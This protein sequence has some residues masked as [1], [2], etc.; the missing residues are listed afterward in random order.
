[1][2]ALVGGWSFER[3]KFNRA[4]QASRQL[5]SAFKPFVWG[6][7]LEVGFT[8][9]DTLFDGP[10]AFPG[11]GG[12]PPYS[13]RN[14]SREYFGITTLRRALERSINVTAV[15][16]LDLVGVDRVIEFANRLGVTSPLPPVLSLALGSA[17]V[18]PME[19]AAAY[20]AI[21]NQ[22]VWV[23]PYFI[24]SVADSRGALLERARPRALRSLSPQVAYVLTH[25][26]EGVVDRGTAASISGLD[27]D[28]AGKTGTTDQYSDA[29]FVGFT[30]RYTLLVW[31]GHDVKRS[32]GRQM[33][34]TRVALPIWA[35]LIEDG[36][37]NGW[38]TEGERFTPPPGVV[39]QPVEL[40]SGLL[41]GP[42]AAAIVEEAFLAG[43]QPVQ[44]Y[45]P[46]WGQV[47][48]RPWYLQ[49]PHYLPKAGE[50]MPEDVEDWQAVMEAWEEK[51]PPADG[52]RDG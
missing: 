50:R 22:G 17:D 14:H 20:A 9:A 19:V 27:I 40:T 3:S 37:E 16:L 39:L 34:G 36:L 42:G 31:V 15:K 21:A 12:R 1:M 5:G 2:R 38:L 10:V 43:T 13:P 23:E 45:T 18:V 28:L 46:E 47:L 48:E 49:R 29:W 26:L 24:D 51:E 6:A 32:I 7:A 4:V 25:L 30:P 41:P 8:P 33:T 52:R 35:D 44:T 11:G